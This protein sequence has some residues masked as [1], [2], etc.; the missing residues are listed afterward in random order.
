MQFLILFVLIFLSKLVSAGFNFGKYK[1]G[2]GSTLMV[3]LGR[4]DGPVSP[5]TDNNLNLNNMM[6]H[7]IENQAASN[8]AQVRV[9][10]NNI[11]IERMFVESWSK[12]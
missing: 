9:P 11:L 7:G 5:E 1:P 6:D 3:G 10:L 12:L 4:D 8:T 2:F